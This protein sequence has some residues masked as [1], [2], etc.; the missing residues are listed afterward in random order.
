MKSISIIV[1]QSR[2]EADVYSKVNPIEPWV[3]FLERFK[4]WFEIQPITGEP[5]K[6]MIY[7]HGEMKVEENDLLILAQDCVRL[8]DESASRRTNSK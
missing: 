4:P 7:G 3:S 1:D 5:G 2:K 8:V 6:F